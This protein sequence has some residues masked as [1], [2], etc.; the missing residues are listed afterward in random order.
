LTAA[1]SLGASLGL[2]MLAASVALAAAPAET[3]FLNRRLPPAK[4]SSQP[5]R[6]YQVYVPVDYTPARTWPIILFLHGSGERGDDGLRQTNGSLGD[7]IRNHPE[8]FPAIVVFPQCPERTSWVGETAEAALRALERSIAEFRGDPDRV[9]LV[10]LSRG[11]RGAID[12][13]ASHPDRFAAVVAVCGW[14]VKPK[15]LDAEDLP[16][17]I[18]S[19]PY[20]AKAEQLKKLPLRLYH[21][22][23]DPLVPPQESRLLADALEAR[24]ADV[25][26]TIYPGVGHGAW[27]PAFDDE[28]LWRWLFSRK[29]SRPRA[30]AR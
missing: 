29:R 25:Q 8:R 16:D 4:G 3:G 12:L 27:I 21:G 26:L 15:G 22:D 5:G 7:A 20:A 13:G 18:E 6:R 1:F 9:Y 30:G 2:A 28:N 10:G 19:D 23:A 11:G 14:I 24:G 17:T